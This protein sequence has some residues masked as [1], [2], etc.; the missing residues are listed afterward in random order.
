MVAVD[1]DTIRAVPL[2]DAIDRVKMVDI[3][4]DTV[5]TARDQGVSFGE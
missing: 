4:S 1:A 2:R 3:T 5:Q